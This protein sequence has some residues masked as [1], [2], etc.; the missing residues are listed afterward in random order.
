LDAELY[1]K[2][3]RQKKNTVHKTGIK[4]LTG[5]VQAGLPADDGPE[6]VAGETL[7]DAHVL[8]LVQ[9]ADV[10]VPPHQ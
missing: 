3:S 8:L 1:P 6:G 7:V 4:E 5:H 9:V 2:I 10:E